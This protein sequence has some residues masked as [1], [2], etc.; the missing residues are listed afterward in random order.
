MK[1]GIHFSDVFGV[2]V[3]KLEE[4]G[5]FNVSL[6]NDM[7]LFIDPFLLFSS[8]KPEYQRLHQGI[9]NY[10]S[11]LKKK[12]EEGVSVELVKSLY[13]FHE[14]KQNWLGYSE[15]GN[16]GHGLGFDFAKSMHS[17]MP[18]VFRDLGKETVTESSHLEKVGLFKQ[19]V[20]KDAISDFTTNLILDYLL[21]Y[22]QT[23]A[24]KHIA[25]DKLAVFGVKKA[26][27]DYSVQR[28]MPAR[29]TLPKFGNSYVILTPK[30][31]LT[32]E[33]TWINSDDMINRF[34]EISAS[35]ENEELRA[36]L[37]DYFS[38]QIPVFEMSN[39]E[40]ERYVR[41]AIWR[42]I[43][44]YP[45]IIDYY[46]SDKEKDKDGAKSI[47]TDRM[48]VVEDILVTWVRSFVDENLSKTRFFE[49]KHN[50]S[51]REALKRLGYFK[52]CLENNDVYKI[53]YHNGKPA[54]EEI[55]QLAFKLVWG[56]S[57]YDVNREVNNGRGPA[58]YKISKGAKDS[59]IIEFKLARNPRLK[60]NLQKQLSIY[61]NANDTKYGIAVIVFFS[62]EEKKK[63]E[64]ILREL[65][66]DN[67]ENVVL[68]DCSPKKSG[69]KE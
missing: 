2:S 50:S 8:P 4:Y 48:M 5:A 21:G 7:P 61:Q 6:I 41:E 44:K 69:S 9:L 13:S 37:N 49:F 20:G 27:F 67:R 60:Q 45:D 19:G 63:V 54:R 38:R 46:I 43:Q 23:F 42:T 14:V 10:L 62:L 35:I 65:N 64:T 29:Y 51:Y 68:I 53:L 3:E 32:R 31:L 56:F 25:Q 26:Y 33:E 17:M 24:L 11:F 47:A 57:D 18:I 55:V 36:A 16:C 39:K 28:W 52:N 59:A 30:D 1:Y 34:A 40:R 12:A 22:T 15:C 66:I 58:D